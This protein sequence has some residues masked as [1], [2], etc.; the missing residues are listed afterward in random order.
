MIRIGIDAHIADVSRAGI[1]QLTAALL[2]WLPKVDPTT[3]YVPLRPA[4]RSRDFRMPERWWWDQVAVPRMAAKETLSVVLKTGFS[5]P[6][7]SPVPTVIILHDLA[8][9]RFPHELHKPSAW[10]YGRWAPWTLRFARRVI[11]MSEFTAREA[12]E[13]LRLPLEKVRVVYQGGDDLASPKPQSVDGE[14]RTKYQLPKNFVLHVGTIEP[15][16]NL[17]FLVRAFAKFRQRHP[18][19]QLVLAGKEGWLSADAHDTVPGLDVKDAVRFLGEVNDNERR[20]LYRLARFL[21]LPSRYEGFGRPTIEAMRSG[22]PVVAAAAGAI[23]EAVGDAALVIQGYDEEM[24]AS[25]MSDLAKDERRRRELRGKGLEQC[26][27]FSWE[28]AAREIADILH[29]VVN[30]PR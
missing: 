7:R 17:A 14:V 15:R 22:L 11:A 19:Y 3:E 26:K 21:V 8:A 2:E 23:P 5:A 16:K 1:G 29:E 10:F 6:V 27:K 12:T 13:L 24:W 4:N 25:A 28:R 18:E 30:E 20:S 9:R